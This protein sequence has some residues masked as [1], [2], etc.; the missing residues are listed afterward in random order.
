MS[1]FL[2][3]IPV[4]VAIL[5]C[6]STASCSSDG[7]TGLT[8]IGTLTVSIDSDNRL[9]LPSGEISDIECGTH[10]ETSEIRLS[11]S[12]SNGSYRHTWENFDKFPQEESYFAGT[13]TLDVTS[14]NPENEGFNLPSFSGTA[15]VAIKENERTDAVVE[16]SPSSSFFHITFDESITNAFPST[17][18]FAHS[19]GN[20]YFT[21]LP[22]ESRMLCLNPSSAEILLSLEIGGK[23]IVFRAMEFDETKAATLY[24]ISISADTSGENPE[25][26]VSSGKEILTFTLTPEFLSSTPPE[27]KFSTSTDILLPEGDIPSEPVTATVTA[28]YGS[29]SHLILSTNSASLDEY[30]IPAEVD[31]LNQ[32]VEEAAIFNR[33][34]LTMT[35]DSESVRV[36]FT[37]MLGNLVYLTPDNALSTFSLIASNSDGL[38]SAPT[39]L[40]VTTTPVEI[41]VMDATDAVM[42]IDRT[43]V[44]VRCPAP[45]FE[46]HV[47][48]E[49]ETSPD[50]W[51]KTPFTITRAGQN[52]YELEFS[53]PEG[54]SPANARVLYCE[55]VR[56]TFSINR[57]LPDFGVDIDGFAKTASIRIKAANP[58]LTRKIT[59]RINV[60]I[61]GVAVPVY[62]RFPESGVVTVI[63]LKPHTTYTIKTTLMDGVSDPVFTPEEKITTEDTPQIT[64]ADFEERKDGPRA[65]DMPSGGVYAQ[66]SVDIFNWQHHTDFNCEI[67]KN[68][69]NTNEK[70]FNMSS[71][72]IN[73]WYV[74]PSAQLMRDDAA[75]GSF[76][77]LLTSVAYDPDGDEI[78]PYAQTGSPYLDYSPIIPEIKYRAAGKLFLGSYSYDRASGSET[79]KEGISWDSRPYSLSGAYKYLPCTADR[80]D[81]GL[82]I[83]EV[84]GMVDGKENVIAS[85]RML[86]PYAASF[87]AFNVPLS[88]NIFGVKATRLKVMFA[89]SQ[90]IGSIEEESA[91]VTTVPDPLTATSVGGKLWIDNVTLTY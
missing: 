13:Y 77:V 37:S 73:T 74:Q 60:Y 11:M 63:D 12:D 75:G 15:E 69:A 88:Y 30:Q 28:P 61:D 22:G 10:P 79:Y 27:I 58:E 48:V 20:I 71:S 67:P 35:R 54:S 21:Y 55:E 8:G 24:T 91:N 36:D 68:W 1:R 89:S 90:H 43:K 44:K 53:I 25:I 42:C 82:V 56:S 17:K 52:L 16:I 78:P 33:L 23:E 46:N 84:L 4:Y 41:E 40:K 85:G 62:R 3:H 51:E 5:L 80:D 49:I 66:T 57:I 26:T 83:V 81:G 86:L 29:I 87:T 34:G 64:N 9:R 2:R 39:T 70:T 59:E 72:N 65:K 50:K 19:K 47:D 18:A 6:M 38:M 45:G 76:S 31:L 7:S 32:T 14:G